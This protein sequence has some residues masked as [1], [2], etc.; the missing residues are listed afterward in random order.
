[1]EWDYY[2][3]SVPVPLTPGKEVREL[4]LLAEYVDGALRQMESPGWELISHDLC[5]YREQ[6]IL[7]LIFRRPSEN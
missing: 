4:S 2:S 5:S 6:L 7:T 3:T 1:M